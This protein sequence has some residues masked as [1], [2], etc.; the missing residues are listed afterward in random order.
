MIII[1]A[2]SIPFCFCV[3]GVS[4]R[5]GRKQMAKAPDRSPAQ[6]VSVSHPIASHLPIHHLPTNV[7]KLPSIEAKPL[8]PSAPSLLYPAS[9][10]ST[11]PYPTVAILAS[12]FSASA[13]KLTCIEAC[14]TVPPS[15]SARRS[16]ARSFAWGRDPAKHN[17]MRHC[18]PVVAQGVGLA[19]GC[20][21]Q[22]GTQRSGQA[23]GLAGWRV[24][25]RTGERQVGAA[26]LCS[27]IL[28]GADKQANKRRVRQ[29]PLPLKVRQEAVA[30]A[31]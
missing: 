3:L 24:D 28:A 17:A 5:N 1:P 2:S 21:V 6:L 31:S 16:L 15:G 8:A 11:L 9:P 7:S 14:S 25:G 18:R 20:I 23:D 13:Q 29:T 10:Q 4:I 26:L 19:L 12:T 30:G 27:A 22:A